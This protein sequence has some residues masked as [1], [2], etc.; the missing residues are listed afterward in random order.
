MEAAIGSDHFG[1]CLDSYDVFINDDEDAITK[2]DTN[3]EKYQ[4]LMG[5]PELNYD[6]DNSDE[7]KGDKTYDQYIEDKVALPNWKGD[8]SWESTE[9]ASSIMMSVCGKV[10]KMKCKKDQ[11]MKLITQWHNGA[12]YS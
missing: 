12:T 4:V 11:Y 9:S 2:G 5:Y 10:S 3:D 6:K 7:D 8:N 1:I